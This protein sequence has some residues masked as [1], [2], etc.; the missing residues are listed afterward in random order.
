MKPFGE[1]ARRGEWTRWFF[2]ACAGEAS[3]GGIAFGLGYVFNFSPLAHCHVRLPDILIGFGA[4]VPPFFLFV[5]ML[6]A[7]SEFLRDV[8]MTLQQRVGPLFGSWSIFQLAVVSTLAGGGEELLFRGLIQGGL[9]QGAGPF[10]SLAVASFLFG[11]VHPI[12]L[13]YALVTAG[14]GIYLGAL[15]IVTDNLVP[16]IVAHAAYDFF[17]L[18]YFLRVYQASA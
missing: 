10:F 13:N 8:R 1:Q 14:V 15:Y 18:I 9:A 16:P 7:K 6:K 17:A 11:C 5:G 4:A 3:L 12:T 2:L